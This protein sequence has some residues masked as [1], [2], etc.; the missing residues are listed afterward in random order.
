MSLKNDLMSLDILLSSRIIPEQFFQEK[1][2][3]K[4]IS[5]IREKARFI[6]NKS[7]RFLYYLN[8]LIANYINSK[9]VSKR[10]FLHIEAINYI[11]TA[12]YL[13]KEIKN[14]I[15]DLETTYHLCDLEDISSKNDKDFFKIAPYLLDTEVWHDVIKRIGIKY[16]SGNASYFTDLITVIS[17]NSLEKVGI[18]MHFQIGYI[19]ELPIYWYAEHPHYSD[20]EDIRLSKE[21]FNI[22]I[23]NDDYN[24][25]PIEET[26]T[27][28][29]YN[30]HLT[31]ICEEIKL[32]NKEKFYITKSPFDL[33][34]FINVILEP[35]DKTQEIEI[36]R[37]INNCFNWD[38]SY[39][40]LENYGETIT[41]L[42][43]ETSKL[44]IGCLWYLKTTNNIISYPSDKKPFAEILENELK[45]KNKRGLGFSEKLR[46]SKNLGS[47]KALFEKS[48]PP[49]IRAGYGLFT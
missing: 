35:S 40:V 6:N 43:K 13:L 9:N 11:D 10:P 19:K 2:D 33:Y 18:D 39:G 4:E 24:P 17:S 28:Q 31:Q 49:S 44:L 41:F 36:K 14:L 29:L 21:L 30:K 16:F 45:L 48:F 34:K 37:F 27:D 3:H 25:N 7:D 42:N 46:Q 32:S 5:K 22:D 12:D 26:I 1:T 20:E 47:Y 23:V 15:S 38:S 8:R